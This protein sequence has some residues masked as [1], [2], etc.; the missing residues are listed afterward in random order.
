MSASVA[1]AARPPAAC[2]RLAVAFIEANLDAPLTLEEIV[3]ASGVSGRGL[4]RHFRRAMGASPMAW[5]RDARFRRVRDALRCARFEDRI[6]DIA[7]FWGFDH[8]GRF[9]VE[10]RRRFGEKPS[11]TRASAR[12]ARAAH[13]EGAAPAGTSERRQITNSPA[14]TQPV[15][16]S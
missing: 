13:L 6:V 10:Y 3:R 11:Q 1:I 2:V 7:T 12:A 8:M 9:A 15:E 4:F 5:L 14:M 16:M